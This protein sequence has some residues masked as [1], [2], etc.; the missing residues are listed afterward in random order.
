MEIARGK[1]MRL[2]LSLMLA[3]A[4]LGMSAVM[5]GC[6]ADT[7]DG[8]TNGDANG[9]TPSVDA[10]PI[11]I[12]WVPWDE[13]IAVTYL[14]KHILESE[15][16]EVN[17]TQLDIAP[18]YAGVAEG[19]LDLYLDAWLPITHGDYADEYD[20]N[21]EYL[22]VWN[23]NGLLTWAV[24]DYVDVQSIPDLKGKSDMFNGQIIGI[25]AGAGLMRLSKDAVI[26]GY[27]LEEYTLV[28]GST[29]AMLAELDRAV[30][31]EEPIVVTLWRPHWAYGAYPM[32]DLED[33]EGHLGGA[34]ELHVVAHKG[35]S[36]EY[37]EV[38]EWLTNFKLSDEQIG[39]LTN[40]VI[41]EYGTGQEAEGIE[42][43]LSDP[44]N[45]ALV[46]GWLGK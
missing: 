11:E 14:W 6:D 36:D 38:A 13:D 10:D 46:D 43:W 8:D 37:P 15:G 39:S 17:L 3:V 5:A 28:E 22:G 20:E 33:P 2:I 31:N 25:E 34:E 21:W 30:S 32:R 12:G 26:P 27:G 45:Q 7:T 19:D 24:P 44:A 40:T 1:G 4:L 23:D 29:S 42:D 16:Y 41:Q 18:V 35:F 9:E